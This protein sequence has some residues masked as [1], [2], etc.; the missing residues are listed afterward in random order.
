MRCVTFD[1]AGTTT[2]ASNGTHTHLRNAWQWAFALKTYPL[3]AGIEHR[4]DWAESL[5]VVRGRE[6]QT[7]ARTIDLSRFP[8]KVSAPCDPMRQVAPRC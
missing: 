1:I 6:R 2:L 3:I 8:T 7:A 4:L 5:R